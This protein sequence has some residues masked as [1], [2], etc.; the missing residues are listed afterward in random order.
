MNGEVVRPERIHIALGK[1]QILSV[2]ETQSLAILP[3]AQCTL[4]SVLIGLR[5]NSKL[6]DWQKQRRYRSLFIIQGWVFAM[7]KTIFAGTVEKT[8]AKTS[9]NRQNQ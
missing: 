9:K 7:A 3:F 5:L 6:S 2:V 4:G 8:V 1:W